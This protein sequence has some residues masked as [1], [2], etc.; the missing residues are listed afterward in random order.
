M[1][2]PHA[3]VVLLVIACSGSVIAAE[4]HYICVIK[5]EY[6]LTDEGKLEVGPLSQYVVDQRLV[7]DRLTGIMRGKFLTT[8]GAN[9]IVVVDRQQRKFIQVVLD[10]SQRRF[11]AG[12]IP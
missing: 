1:K 6:T 5:A 10:S 4:D 2:R 11:L 7:V 12:R 9:N 3:A 8:A